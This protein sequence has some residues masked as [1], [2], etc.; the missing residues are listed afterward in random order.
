VNL[1]SYFK[2]ELKNLKKFKKNNLQKKRE[3]NVLSHQF[4]SS[5]YMNYLIPFL[6]LSIEESCKSLILSITICAIVVAPFNERCVSSA[7]SLS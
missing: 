2:F 3:L 5:Y 1:Y 6:S 4:L 7:L